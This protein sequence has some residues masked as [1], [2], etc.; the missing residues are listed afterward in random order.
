MKG[1][2]KRGIGILLVTA[3]LI[4]L[5]GCGGE[6]NDSE[7][8]ELYTNGVTEIT[9]DDILDP[10]ESETENGEESA[11]TPQPVQSDG[12]INPAVTKPTAD[13]P[14]S[15][16]PSNSNYTGGTTSGTPTAS[17]YDESDLV[18]YDGEIHHIFFHQ[19]IAYPEL[20]FDG[21]SHEEG[22]DDWMVTVSELN[23]ILDSLYE[24]NYYLVNWNDVWVEYTNENGEQRMKQQTLMIPKGKIPLVISIDDTCY[25]Q[26]Y[27]ENG[28]MEKLIIGDDGDIWAYGHDPQG[29]EVTTQDLDIIPILDKFV[30]QHPD[31]SM[32]GV[33]ACLCLTGYEGILGYRTNTDTQSWTNEDE[34][35]RLLEV[36]AVKPIVERLKETGWYFGCHTWG[37]IRLESKSLE[38]VKSDMTRWLNEVGSI[39]GETKL[40]IYPHGSRPDGNDWTQTGEVFRYLQGLGFR[41]F[42]SVGVENFVYIK[43]DICAVILDRLHPDGT[44]LRWERDTYLPY[45]DAAEVFDYENRPTGAKPSGNGQYGYDFS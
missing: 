5:A 32:N 2:F 14:Y 38:T 18:A 39:V 6:D 9:V 19:V 40:M 37:H 24:K 36:E 12:T 16:T 30:K 7:N 3:M 22:I 42:A 17:G 4:S 31:F 35:N 8:D 26:M 13:D 20:A 34:A 25:Y 33:K 27:C 45:F 1:H 15:V 41:I 23:K 44:T 43:K 21:D 29:N 28:F 11:E 10:G